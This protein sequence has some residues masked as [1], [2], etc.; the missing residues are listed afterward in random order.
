[1]LASFLAL[2]IQFCYVMQ[3][4]APEFKRK[5]A[6]DNLMSNGLH[7]EAKYVMTQSHTH[8]SRP[9]GCQKPMCLL[10]KHSYKKS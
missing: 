9:R 6:H 3:L 5:F 8:S 1:M 2:K 4:S 10:K 7:I